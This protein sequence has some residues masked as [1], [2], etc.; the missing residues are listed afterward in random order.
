MLRT[1]TRSPKRPPR[2]DAARSPD[3]TRVFRDFVRQLERL[4]AARAKPSG[5]GGR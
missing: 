3:A 1:S 5:E 2:S 4:D